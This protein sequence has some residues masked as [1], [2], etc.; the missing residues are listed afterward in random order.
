MQSNK[1][2]KPQDVLQAKAYYF[3]CLLEKTTDPVY[4][5]E[6]KLLEAKKALTAA[7]E[8][9][10]RCEKAMS[11]LTSAIAK[12]SY[13]NVIQGSLSNSPETD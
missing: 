10:H 7:K 5:P 3:E 4:W 8:K 2:G 11:L 12:A 9:G 13:P 1:R 6:E